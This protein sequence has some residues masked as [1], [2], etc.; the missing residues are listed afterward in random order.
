M[1]WTLCFFK[2][3]KS[4]V[5]NLGFSIIS[6]D[7]DRPWGGFFLIDEK[8][9]QKFVHNLISKEINIR[10]QKISPKILIITDHYFYNNK[11]I[12]TLKN[13]KSIIDE[14]PS[15][16]KIVVIPYGKKEILITDIE[17]IDWNTI[18]KD[19]NKEENNV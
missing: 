16:E 1:W 10:N 18:L 11:K 7:F 14:I 17:Y 8:Q 4:E 5:E 15:I 19:T 2:N 6:E 9:S 13:I 3:I 12:D